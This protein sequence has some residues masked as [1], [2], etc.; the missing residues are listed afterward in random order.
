MN[1][2]EMDDLIIQKA[3]CDW[4]MEQTRELKALLSYDSEGI[5]A[6]NKQRALAAI[7]TIKNSL[8]ELE[9]YLKYL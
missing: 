4:I 9:L 5:I 1:A 2:I 8:F 6:C 3:H 7:G